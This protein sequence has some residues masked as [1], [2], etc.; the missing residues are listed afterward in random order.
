MSSNSLRALSS[1]SNRAECLYVEGEALDGK[2][3]TELD[4]VDV[5]VLVYSLTS[6]ES[7]ERAR[8]HWLPWIKEQ[9]SKSKKKR[10]GGIPIVLVANKFDV[11]V[12]EHVGNASELLRQCEYYLTCLSHLTKAFV[13]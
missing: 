3:Q 7:I 9:Q 11:A 8:C 5:V 6:T 4:R 12:S 2:A 10:N 1:S 13:D